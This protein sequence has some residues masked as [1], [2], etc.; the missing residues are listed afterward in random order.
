MR[1]ELSSLM[2]ELLL[3]LSVNGPLGDN[4]LC[5]LLMLIINRHC[6]SVDYLPHTSYPGVFQETLTLK[7]CIKP[8]TEA[9]VKKVRM[10]QLL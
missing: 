8:L 4:I 3:M 10:D 5:F 2:A 9:G 6:V 7:P 1:I